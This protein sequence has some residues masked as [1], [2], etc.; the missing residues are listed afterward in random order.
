TVRDP[1][2]RPPEQGEL[3]LRPPPADP[4][5]AS[6]VEGVELV[7]ARTA[8]A[9]VR[10]VDGEARL[11]HVGV[12]T[13]WQAEVRPDGWVETWTARVAGPRGPDAEARARVDA[14]VARPRVAL[15]V[16]DPSGEG[17]PN[18]RIDLVVASD[19]GSTVVHSILL[20]AAS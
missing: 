5:A 6:A 8:V 7:A 10:V 3:H 12:G 1:E 19:R 17:F 9:R 2:G 16:S 20:D 4:D 14:P 13:S 15:V 11:E 18:R